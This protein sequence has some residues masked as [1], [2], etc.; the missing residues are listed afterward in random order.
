MSDQN[1]P[2]AT[3]KVSFL[4][5]NLSSTLFKNFE[6]K[7]PIPEQTISKFTDFLKSNNI[8]YNPEIE[9]NFQLQDLIQNEIVL[10]RQPEHK[11]T[12]KTFD[13]FPQFFS[14]SNHTKS[15]EKKPYVQIEY[16]D[17]I[18]ANNI[19]EIVKNRSEYNLFCLS[20]NEIM[21]EVRNTLFMFYCNQKIIYFLLSKNSN[22]F[23]VISNLHF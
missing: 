7:N 16:F 21:S 1:L 11:T 8:D 3:F 20:A 23:K 10:E 19:N 13:T 17:P 2:S 12:L 4:T 5:T 14:D 22:Y 9:P 15:S 18:F 6:L